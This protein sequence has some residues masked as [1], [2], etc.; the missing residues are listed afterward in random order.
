MP[1]DPIALKEKFEQTGFSSLT[2][3]ERIAASKAGIIPPV[4]SERE[5]QLRSRYNLMLEDYEQMLLD[6]GGVCRICQKEWHT[7][8][9]VDHDHSTGKIRDLLCQKCNGIVAIVEN[10]LDIVMEALGYLILHG[11]EIND[12]PDYE[13]EGWK[14]A[15]YI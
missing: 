11:S 9:Y 4:R 13:W 14:Y 6:Q 2:K 10:H 5:R 12:N 1:H 7:T 3:G 8:L 15:P